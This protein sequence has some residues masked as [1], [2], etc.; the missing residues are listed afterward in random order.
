MCRVDSFVRY[1]QTDPKRFAWKTSG[2]KLKDGKEFLQNRM[3]FFMGYMDSKKQQNVRA[4]HHASEAL[5]V[6]STSP[7]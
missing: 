6:H 5:Q 2:P 3:P 7:F 4:C 1:I